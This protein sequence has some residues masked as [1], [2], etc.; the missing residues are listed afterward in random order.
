[1]L[2]STDFVVVLALVD[3][4]GFRPVLARGWHDRPPRPR[5][6]R[7]ASSSRSQV[8]ARATGAMAYLTWERPSVDVRWRLSLAVAIVTQLVTRSLMSGIVVQERT[9][10]MMH[11]PDRSAG[12]LDTADPGGTL[13]Q[14]ASIAPFAA[15]QARFGRW[16]RAAAR[17]SP[18][19]LNVVMPTQ[20]ALPLVQVAA[21]HRDCCHLAYLPCHPRPL[22]SGIMTARKA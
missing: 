4:P 10:R 12:S 6:R 18:S 16:G 9:W 13:H 2:V 22:L 11:E 1:M 17:M 21:A 20:V 7:W 8:A 14:G 3:V 15:A 19:I 5:Y